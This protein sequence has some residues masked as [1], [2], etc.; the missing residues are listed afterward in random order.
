MYKVYLA[1]SFPS[2]PR[3]RDYHEILSKLGV[4]VV[5]TW[6]FLEGEDDSEKQMRIHALRDYEEVE[7]ADMLLLFDDDDAS[8]GGGKYTEMG[9]ALAWKKDVGVIGRNTNIFWHLPGVMTSTWE[10]IV[11]ELS[12]S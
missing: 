1:G 5:S 12:G 8:V 4:R 9:M 2:A 3:L 10:E 11:E 6:Y 7:S